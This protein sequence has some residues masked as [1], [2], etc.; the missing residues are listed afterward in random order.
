MTSEQS[1]RAFVARH[2]ICAVPRTEC[3]VLDSETNDAE[4]N[5]Q[6]IIRHFNLDQVLLSIHARP[7][8]LGNLLFPVAAV[9]STAV[10]RS[11]RAENFFL[12]PRAERSDH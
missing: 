5:A 12:V 11:S 6:H 4:V 8:A 1:I 7:A 10:D 9:A 3:L 2:Q